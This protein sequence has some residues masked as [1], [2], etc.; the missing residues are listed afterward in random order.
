MT[1]RALEREKNQG[2]KEAA[3]DTLG[4]L[5]LFQADFARCDRAE[6]SAALLG[7]TRSGTTYAGLIAASCGGT[8]KAEAAA[9][10]LN[11]DY[12]LDAVAQRIDIPQIH[13]RLELQR[14]N[15]GKAVDAIHPTQLYQ[16]GYVANG[17]PLYL[18]GT[19]YL[20]DKQGTQAVAEFQKFLDHRWAFGSSP[21]LAL[22]TLG[23]AR[24]HALAGNVAKAR[25][26]YQDFLTMWKDAD[27]DLPV[28]LAAKQEYAKLPQ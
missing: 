10:R 16:M 13:G 25:T 9:V 28:L 24:A 17:I 21:Y 11:S 7:S 22:C 8:Q 2:L 23:L 12:P 3:D 27:T 19:A 6:R 20:L 18:R 5:A 14:R 26:A 15:G 1:G 4:W